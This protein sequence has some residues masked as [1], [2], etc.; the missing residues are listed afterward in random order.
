MPL[1]CVFK[2]SLLV[3]NNPAWTHILE[4]SPLLS[5]DF[6]VCCPRSGTAG[7]REHIHYSLS[8]D[9]AYYTIRTEP[10]L[11]SVAYGSIHFFLPLVTST[12]KYK[13]RGNVPFSCYVLVITIIPVGRHCPTGNSEWNHVKV[14]GLR[15][16]GP[17]EDGI[18][19]FKP[20]DSPS[21]PHAPSWALRCKA[22]HMSCA[23][24][25]WRQ[26]WKSSEDR[27]HVP[28]ILRKN[29]SLT[30]TWVYSLPET[31]LARPIVSRRELGKEREW[32]E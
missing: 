28:P 17:G 31:S 9:G 16:D 10:V 11:L 25:Q 15:Q 4:T 6:L 2:L 7:R 5:C 19:T 26:K 32:K 18:H 22:A 27:L 3:I 21:Q 23:W 24:V 12:S 20:R 30:Q 8:K 29:R 1:F 13:R 14:S